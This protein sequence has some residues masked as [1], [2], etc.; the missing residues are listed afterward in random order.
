MLNF[1]KN[2][3]LNSSIKLIT[4]AYALCLC[5][6]DVGCWNKQLN[7]IFL[8]RERSVS[9]IAISEYFFA[10][11]FGRTLFPTRFFP[12]FFC[13]RVTPV[14]GVPLKTTEV[15]KINNC[16]CMISSSRS[17]NERICVFV[18]ISFILYKF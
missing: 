14:T 16:P 11:F 6:Y 8:V 9:K 4:R 3:M 5:A 17:Q 1:F 13:D 10:Y 12:I 7:E 2:S 15:E 18:N